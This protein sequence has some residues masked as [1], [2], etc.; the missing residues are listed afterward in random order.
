[1]RSM[2]PVSPHIFG[3]DRPVDE[4]VEISVR[5]TAADP[6]ID[7]RIEAVAQDFRRTV[8][9]GKEF[10]AAIGSIIRDAVDY[11]I[12]A[13]N[14]RRYAIDDLEPDE[15]TTIGKRI[16]RLIRM[17][18]KIPKGE[19]LDIRLAG[20]DVDIKTSCT[21]SRSWMF[22]KSNVDHI[23]LL[24]AYDE[25]TATFA[26]GLVLVT[27]DILGAH[28][29]DRK[30]GILSSRAAGKKAANGGG[31]TVKGRIF[32]LVEKHHYPPNFLPTIDENVLQ[33]IV[34][35]K[36]GAERVRRLLTEVTGRPIPGRAIDAVAN[37]QDPK[38]RS[39]G[40]DGARG[41]LWSKKGLLVLSGKFT[42]DSDIARASLGIGLRPDETLSLSRDHPALTTKLVQTYA[43]N[44]RLKF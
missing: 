29:Q 16:E 9:T 14:M 1:M 7:K 6:S 12:D 21:T 37:Q 23:N 15:K 34:A 18:F 4:S 42:R 11:V 35:G 38:R 8:P 27:E 40:L 22:S 41:K 2:Q 5:N 19:K 25:R 39:R 17:R 30:R 44:H 33:R 24:I 10:E 28:N 31:E 20:E 3:V 43:E 13:P 36:T 32:W 26:M